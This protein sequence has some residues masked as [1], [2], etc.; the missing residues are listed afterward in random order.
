MAEH[1]K[2]LLSAYLDHELDDV[3]Q[4]RVEHH[5]SHCSECRQE[6][7][8]LALLKQQIYMAYG[9]V[10]APEGLEQAVMENIRQRQFAY[11]IGKWV[12]AAVAALLAIVVVMTMSSIVYFGTAI[13]SAVVNI[14]FSLLHM[15]PFIVSS[16]PSLLGIVLVTAVIL[17]IVSLWSLHRLLETRAIS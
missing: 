17:I 7:E 5:L 11:G 8:K 3:E 9:S 16:I 12:A 6:F 10:Q 15:I 13:V 14:G 1:V 2:D 4:K